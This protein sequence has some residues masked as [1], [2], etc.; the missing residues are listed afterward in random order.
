[1]VNYAD[2]PCSTCVARDSTLCASLSDADMHELYAIAT[3]QDYHTGEALLHQEQPADYVFSIQRGYA[4]MFRLTADGKRQILAFLFP[5]DFVGF[6]SEDNYHFGVSAIASTRACRFDRR[7]L[8]SLIVKHPEMDRKLRFTLTRAI[9]SFFEL[10]FSLG[11]KD[12]LQKVAAF[13]WF[14]SY[15][16]RKL[17]RPDNPIYLPMRRAD[18][19]D[20]MGLTIETVSRAF[21]AMKASG[22]IRLHGAYEVE[23][24]DMDELRALGVVVAEPS[25]YMHGDDDYY[26]H[27]EPE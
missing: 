18:I 14:I 21:T 12:A 3:E 6:T 10:L 2:L 25:P 1:M 15:R 16:Q 27:K 17:H 13:L 9:D 20:F 26:P 5:G 19:A 7:R 8:E 22:V 4:N 11:R 23:I 24:V